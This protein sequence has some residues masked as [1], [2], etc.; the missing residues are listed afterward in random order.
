MTQYTWHHSV[1]KEHYFILKS[2]RDGY[3]ATSDDEEITLEQIRPYTH[4]SFYGDRPL[5]DTMHT[6]DC[7]LGGIYDGSAHQR[8][9]D[10]T[11]A[12]CERAS[13]HVFNGKLTFPCLHH[14]TQFTFTTL[15][16]NINIHR[17]SMSHEN[18]GLDCL[19]HCLERQ[20]Q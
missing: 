18:E 20:H 17:L 2:R 9:K 8:P 6:E 19:T 7:R 1:I 13:I 14:H 15:I 4:L 3:I 16:T 10:S 12:Y 11:I 5:E